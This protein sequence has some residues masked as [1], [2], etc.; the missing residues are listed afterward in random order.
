[1]PPPR[2]VGGDATPVAARGRFGFA[3]G[4]SDQLPLPPWLQLQGIGNCCGAIAAPA[5]DTKPRVS[6]KRAIILLIIFILLPV[7]YMATYAEIDY[8]VAL[9]FKVDNESLSEIGTAFNRARQWRTI[10]GSM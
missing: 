2:G 9:W 3:V 4:E 10:G 5:I 8:D 7:A 6:T 1:M